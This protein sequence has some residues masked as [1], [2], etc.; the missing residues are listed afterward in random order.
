M[1]EHRVEGL[2]YL[3]VEDILLVAPQ[4]CASILAG[5]LEILEETAPTKLWFAIAE[6][7]RRLKVGLMDAAAADCFVEAVR[8]RTENAKRD[9][10][11]VRALLRPKFSIV[12]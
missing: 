11:R 5:V 6:A 2:D 9:L 3:R 4:H 7:E 10:E 8:I 12:K 1:N